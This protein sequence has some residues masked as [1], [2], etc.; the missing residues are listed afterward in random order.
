[1]F[2]KVH[3][4]RYLTEFDFR[5]NQRVSSA[6]MTISAWRRPLRVLSANA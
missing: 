3:L 4:D 5:Y 1:M 6:S 2:P